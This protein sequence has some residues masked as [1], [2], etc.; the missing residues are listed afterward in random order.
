MVRSRPLPSSIW[1]LRSMCI[2]SMP[3]KVRRVELS[4]SHP[5]R[6]VRGRAYLK[7]CMS[8][9]RDRIPKKLCRGF[10]LLGAV[11]TILALR[12]DR[13]PLYEDAR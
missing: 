4:L 8:K 5:V 1:P 3:T 9:I 13:P 7:P 12:E 2:S 10:L 6:V 11:Q